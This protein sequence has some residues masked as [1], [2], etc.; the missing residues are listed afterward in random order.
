MQ[1]AE[2]ELTFVQ[3]E[4]GRSLGRNWNLNVRSLRI[5]TGKE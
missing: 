2:C 5:G 4:F 1:I 3:N